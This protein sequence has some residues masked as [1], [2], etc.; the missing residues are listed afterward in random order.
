MP[1]FLCSPN[2][3]PAQRTF[4]TRRDLPI[5]S[6]VK[7]LPLGL[8]FVVPML[9]RCHG[10]PCVRASPGPPIVNGIDERVASFTLGLPCPGG[11][12]LHAV[13]EE[14]MLSLARSS[15]VAAMFSV[16]HLGSPATPGG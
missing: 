9:Q 15:P 5:V 12:R 10:A 13:I 1:K 4:Y 3:Q 11:P 6:N 8:S 2:F 16:F 14:A 7:P